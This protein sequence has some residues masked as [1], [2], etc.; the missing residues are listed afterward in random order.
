MRKILAV[1][2]N[3]LHKRTFLELATQSKLCNY[4]IEIMLIDLENTEDNNSS[5]GLQSLKELKN[6]SRYLFYLFNTLKYVYLEA[7]NKIQITLNTIKPDFILLGN[8]TGHYE[9]AIIR[10]AKKYKITTVLLQDGLLFSQMKSNKKTKFSNSLYYFYQKYI[11]RFIGGVKY[12]YGGCNVF[13]SLG[14][15]WSEVVRN[16]GNNLHERIY[17]VSSPYFESFIKPPIESTNT[18]VYNSKNSLCITYFLTNFLSGLNDHK[19]HEL[20]LAEIKLLY[21]KINFIFQEQFS[22]ILKIHPEDSCDNYKSLSQLGPQLEITKNASLDYLFSK[23]NLCLTNF[24][25]IFIQAYF[26]QK[27]CMLSNIGL[28]HTKYGDFILSLNLPT[29]K[30]IEE[31]ESLLVDIKMDQNNNLNTTNFEEQMRRFID[32]D[33]NKSSSQ[34]IIELLSSLEI[35]YD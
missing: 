7:S 10:I 34:R 20:Q 13:L 11:S 28:H 14:H 21:Q 24:S 9:R 15:Y 3:S 31:F 4:D 1:S 32:V 29:L 30:S 27:L 18:P 2:S 23:S 26:N 12:G 16:Y 25:S 22:F 5:F 8:D 6:Q 35:Q 19:A 17:T 33:P